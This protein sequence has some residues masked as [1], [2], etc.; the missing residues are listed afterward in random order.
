[1]DRSPVYFRSR[2][3]KKGLAFAAKPLIYMVGRP[4]LERGTNGLKVHCSTN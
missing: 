3:K 1:M 2:R 4:R